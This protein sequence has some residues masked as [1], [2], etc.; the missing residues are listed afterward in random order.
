MSPANQKPAAWGHSDRNTAFRRA[1]GQN[2]FGHDE[3]SQ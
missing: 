1:R 3:V 2:T